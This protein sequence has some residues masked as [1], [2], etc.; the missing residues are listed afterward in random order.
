MSSFIHHIMNHVIIL[1]NV[2]TTS[3]V[4]VAP[5]V[6]LRRSTRQRRLS[7][8]DDYFLMYAQVCTSSGISFVIEMLGHYHTNQDIDHWKARKK[9]LRRHLLEECQTN[10]NYII[11]YRG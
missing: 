10:N 2:N 1:P 7:I 6:A 3:D 5:K 8:L 4:N 11:Y 9:V